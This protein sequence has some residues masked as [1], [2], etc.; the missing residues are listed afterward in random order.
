MYVEFEEERR[1][2]AAL[3]GGTIQKLL[4]RSDSLRSV[5]GAM[6]DGRKARRYL[7]KTA[8]EIWNGNKWVIPLI[9]AFVASILDPFGFSSA[10]DQRSHVVFNRL[11]AP[12]YTPQGY[13]HIAVVLIDDGYLAEIGD[14]YPMSRYNYLDIHSAILEGDP[15]AVF[16]DFHLPSNRGDRDATWL[17]GNELAVSASNP[18]DPDFDAGPDSPAVWVADF[19]GTPEEL[20]RYDLFGQVQTLQVRTINTPMGEYA[21]CLSSEGRAVPCHDPGARPSP[22]LALYHSYCGMGGGAGC[23]DISDGGT[24]VMQWSRKPEPGR[25]DCSPDPDNL[26]GD[27]MIAARALWRG[28]FNRGNIDPQ[29]AQVCYPFQTIRAVDLAKMDENALGSA[30]RDQ[31]VLVGGYFSDAP[32]ATISPVHG[33]IPGVFV[34]ATALDN[35]I[36]R[37]NGIWR[38]EKKLKGMPIGLTH[39]VELLVLLLASGLYWIAS[40]RDRKWAKH[41]SELVPADQAELGLAHKRLGSS[42]TFLILQVTALLGIGLLIPIVFSVPPT[43]FYGLA[44][45]TIPLLAVLWVV[46]LVNWFVVSVEKGGVGKLLGS[47]LGQAFLLIVVVVILSTISAAIWVY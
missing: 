11:A 8:S 12:F 23:D 14:T 30:F 45:L 18:K 34:H 38:S 44:A 17:L 7:E 31:V 24:M 10:T 6:M 26:V 25:N 33:Q 39:F 32:D 40:A 1:I 35:L 41:A 29:L 5:P 28:F 13:N 46:T 4:F 43:N 15:S 2:F 22:A 3:R 27:S 20:A 16:Y 37:G 21:T 47:R 36:T 19:G 9:L 42:F